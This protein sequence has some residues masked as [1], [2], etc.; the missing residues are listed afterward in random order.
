MLEVTLYRGVAGGSQT[1]HSDSFGDKG[2]KFHIRLDLTQNHT[3]RGR[4]ISLMIEP[5]PD[6]RQALRAARSIIISLT[7]KN[8]RDDHLSITMDEKRELELDGA[9]PAGPR[10]INLN[11]LGFNH[12]MT[13]DLLVD[14]S[15][16][17][18][19]SDGV[20]ISAKV[21]TDFEADGSELLSATAGAGSSD[22]SKECVVVRV[23]CEDD[24]HRH[25]G[26]GLVDF[27]A[28]QEFHAP[29]STR[30]SD[31]RA[32]MAANLGF[33][34][35]AFV[36]HPCLI[37]QHFSGE[38]VQDGTVAGVS[39]RTTLL[40]ALAEF[41]WTRNN[42]AGL[43][44]PMG[45]KE[46]NLV[47]LP[48]MD[49]QEDSQLV[50]LKFY[51]PTSQSLE[52]IGNVLA[53]SS[54]CL[55]S[56]G[57]QV[58]ELIGLAP[59]E[60][61]WGFEELGHSQG[62]VVRQLQDGGALDGEGGQSPLW[63]S[64]APPGPGRAVS[65]QE[66]GLPYGAI[67][68]FQKQLPASTR[69]QMLHEAEI[70]GSSPVVSHMNP[71]AGEAILS[72]P[73]PLPTIP[74]F[75][76]TFV[77]SYAICF[78]PLIHGGSQVGFT[79]KVSAQASC[80]ELLSL[81]IATIENDEAEGRRSD[82]MGGKNI[83]HKVVDHH[84]ALNCPAVT[85][86]WCR[87]HTTIDGIPRGSLT[88][89]PSNVYGRGDEEITGILSS[90]CSGKC[91]TVNEM[92]KWQAKARRRLA[93]APDTPFVLYY[94]LATA[95]HSPSS[96]PLKIRWLDPQLPRPA[97]DDSAVSSPK[98]LQVPVRQD[99]RACDVL[100]KLR[101][102][103]PVRDTGQ[104]RLVAVHGNRILHVFHDNAESLNV[105]HTHLSLRAEELCGAEEQTH[106]AAS[107]V[108]EVVLQPPSLNHFTEPFLLSVG[109]EETI[110]QIRQRVARRMHMDSEH[111]QNVQLYVVLG[112]RDSRQLVSNDDALFKH[113][114]LTYG[115]YLAVRM[116][117]SSEIVL[118][119]DEV[120]ASDTMRVH[121]P[122]GHRILLRQSEARWAT[123]ME[124]REE[125]EIEEVGGLGIVESPR[126]VFGRLVQGRDGS[127]SIQVPSP[128]EGGRFVGQEVSALGDTKSQ[129]EKYN[130]GMQFLVA[131]E[132]LL[133]ME[134]DK[135]A[136]VRIY[137]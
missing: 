63:A 70:G 67:L 78:R 10:S 128:S 49:Q 83:L 32:V 123:A 1:C 118:T 120:N 100:S 41:Q 104:V 72:R 48:R 116:S 75:L 71:M 108:V 30:A 107:R 115:D 87:T 53:R 97:G 54:A 101:Q 15:A 84:V 61:L 12:F 17:Y 124:K 40:P 69:L 16:G 68:C 106:D 38:N 81:L 31:L 37:H 93:V 110:G 34:L 22:T 92:L 114:D 122:S 18:L 76:S 85:C 131:L 125:S 56:L 91:K 129:A 90:S 79:V 33:D 82:S 133:V 60:L 117:N 13:F 23:A 80:R 50:F 94:Q 64:S 99:S 103:A 137:A 119:E 29:A 59:R 3:R 134:Q 7:I 62:S 113:F 42:V 74:M 105:E 52:Y 9:T 14:S 66:F 39:R 132:H 102:M 27:G 4:E 6:T 127:H 51:D 96:V 57:P 98:V 136:A 8:Q 45:C 19:T 130:D 95:I 5:T 112:G 25:V 44:Q 26:P 21:T 65:L 46:L 121:H 58:N 111:I 47:M 77:D 86:V 36:F 2:L 20:I 24:L 126:A 135:D 28:V 43:V 89:S 55:S 73:L 88:R 11:A 35:S 109:M